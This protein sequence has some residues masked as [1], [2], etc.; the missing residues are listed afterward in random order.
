VQYRRLG[1]SGLQVSALGLGCSTLGEIVHGADAENL[2]RD[3]LELGVTFIDTAITYAGGRSEEIVGRAIA[4]RRDEV[5]LATKVGLPAGEGPYRTGLS[6]RRIMAAIEVSLRRLC[7]DHVDLYQAHRPDPSTPV[8]ETLE[9]MDRLVRDGKVR[10]VGA[11]NYAAWQMTR[12]DWISDRAGLSH[13]V[14]AQNRF[15]LL[16]GLDDPHLLD[17]SRELGFGIIPWMPLAAGVLSG[18]YRPGVAPPA[19]TRIGDLE[20]FRREADDDRIAAVER[21][22]LWARERGHTTAELGIAWLFSHPE[23]STVIVGARRREQL[24]ENVKSIDWALTPEEVLEARRVA[25]GDPQ[26]GDTSLNGV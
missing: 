13:W 24:A 12:A 26:H 18:K 17:A 15:N 1:Q 19:G 2:V 23:V 10:Y 14:S 5:V 4:G 3:A 25:S 11:S 22:K 9:A 21:L 16:D 20:R 8:E 7:T 6:R